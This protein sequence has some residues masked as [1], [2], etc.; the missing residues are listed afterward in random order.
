MKNIPLVYDLAITIYTIRWAFDDCHGSN[1]GITEYLKRKHTGLGRYQA[2]TVQFFFILNR[3]LMLFLFSFFHVFF[4]SSGT[5][6]AS[7]LKDSLCTARSI[8][9]EAVNKFEYP[10]RNVKYTRLST[11]G[12]TEITQI[13]LS[14][15]GFRLFLSRGQRHVIMRRS[16]DEDAGRTNW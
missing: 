2:W 3:D 4:F 6:L 7:L 12:L 8:S 1:K 11:A 10:F 13:A 16:G 14:S 9:S 5:F 15:P